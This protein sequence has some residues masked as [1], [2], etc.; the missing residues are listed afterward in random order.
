MS[1]ASGFGGEDTFPCAV[2]GGIQCNPILYH[3]DFAS[4]I[5]VTFVDSGFEA[6]INM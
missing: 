3:G 6:S 4:L 2:V 5:S 1:P